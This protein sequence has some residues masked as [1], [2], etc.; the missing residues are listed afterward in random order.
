MA[1]MPDDVI[2]TPDRARSR[3]LTAT[4]CFPVGNLAPE[5]SVIKST[6]I[7]PSLI[8]EDNVYPAIADRRAFLR[9]KRRRSRRSSRARSATAT[10]WC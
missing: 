8:G 2:M 3:G 4:V 1:S 10:C 7:D 6:A 5:G 9:P